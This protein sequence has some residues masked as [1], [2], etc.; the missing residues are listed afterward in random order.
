MCK[1]ELKIKKVK[2]TVEMLKIKIKKCCAVTVKSHKKSLAR[3]KITTAEG[4]QSST[5]QPIHRWQAK[6]TAVRLS[7]KLGRSCPSKICTSE[8]KK[9]K[10]VTRSRT[11]NYCSTAAAWMTAEAKEILFG[12][13]N[14]FVTQ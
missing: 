12:L 4:F 1:N 2:K 8:K 14:S 6:P 7:H 3:I 9:K 10:T 5:L 11:G 13:P